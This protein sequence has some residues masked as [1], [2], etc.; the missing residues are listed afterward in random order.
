[1]TEITTCQT[2]EHCDTSESIDK[3]NA[4]LSDAGVCT[5]RGS[6][7]AHKRVPVWLRGC[8]DYRVDPDLTSA[9]VLVEM[10]RILAWSR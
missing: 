7:F 6:Y 10:D 4:D 9:A 8:P 2:C 5:K 3:R 1:M